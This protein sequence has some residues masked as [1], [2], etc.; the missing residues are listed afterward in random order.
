M[1]LSRTARPLLSVKRVDTTQINNGL[2]GDFLQTLI[3][4]LTQSAE[5]FQAPLIHQPVHKT[6]PALLLLLD[7]LCSLGVGIHSRVCARICRSRLSVSSCN[8]ERSWVCS[9]VVRPEQ[10]FR[11]HQ[12]RGCSQVKGNHPRFDC[13]GSAL[14]SWVPSCVTNGSISSL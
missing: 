8:V 13:Q 14:V 5:L 9:M 1:T 3:A 11:G 4:L 12:R 10:S 6:F 7:S 2:V